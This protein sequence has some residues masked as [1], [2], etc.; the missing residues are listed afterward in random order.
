MTVE[1]YG[2][3]TTKPGNLLPALSKVGP[4]LGQIFMWKLLFRRSIRKRLRIRTSPK[5]SERPDRHPHVSGLRYALPRW[6]GL[7]GPPA[8]AQAFLALNKYPRS[9]TALSNSS[10]ISGAFLLFASFVVIRRSLPFRHANSFPILRFRMSPN[11]S[12]P[13]TILITSSA[14]QAFP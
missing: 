12:H 2:P 8:C 4:S 6:G 7:N 9:F 5:I 13:I 11:A 3:V 10:A 14:I 1:I